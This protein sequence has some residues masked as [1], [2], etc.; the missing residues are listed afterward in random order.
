ML[1]TIHANPQLAQEAVHAAIRAWL[2]E[3]VE[4]LISASSTYFEAAAEEQA[5]GS[6]PPLE[7]AGVREHAQESGSCNAGSV[8]AERTE[9]VDDKG[10][11]INAAVEWM[12]TS[13]GFSCGLEAARC[14]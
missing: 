4:A 1:V 3:C 9:G 7:C 6:S 14:R 10:V 2:A 12:G 8:E 13:A 11:C 5:A